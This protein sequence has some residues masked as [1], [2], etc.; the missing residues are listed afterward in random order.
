MTRLHTL[1]LALVLSGTAAMAQ[2]ETEWIALFNGKSLEGWKGAEHPDSFKVEDGMLVVNGHRGHL[3]FQGKE[4]QASFTDFELEADLALG[5]R[6]E[7]E[8][9]HRPGSAR[10][11]HGDQAGRL[12]PR[13]GQERDD[14]RP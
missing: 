12:G 1:M 8:E 9:R 13:L 10:G 7:Q 14:Q 4:G 11:E 2:A 6:G 3:F 5:E